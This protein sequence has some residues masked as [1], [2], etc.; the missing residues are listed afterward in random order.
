MIA[1]ADQFG[2]V[3]AIDD[4]HDVV[5]DGRLIWLLES[6]PHC[7]IERKNVP[8]IV[9][10]GSNVKLV[11]ISSRCVKYTVKKG[12]LVFLSNIREFLCRISCIGTYVCYNLLIST[13]IGHAVQEHRRHAY[14]P[15]KAFHLA[16]QL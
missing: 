14:P 4:V 11:A 5:V 12:T 9:G 16:N 1:G 8:N 13:M 2:G 6:Y 3:A 7:R 15:R 10:R